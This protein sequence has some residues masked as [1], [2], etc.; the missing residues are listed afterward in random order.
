MAHEFGAQP[1]QVGDLD[2]TAWRALDRD[3][4]VDDVEVLRRRLELLGRDLEQLAPGLLGRLV[5]GAADAVGDLAATRRGT[6]GRADR[7]PD[8]D[9]DA[10]RRDAERLG[11]DH[12]QAGGRPADVRR[13]DRD[14]HRSVHLDAASRG[15]RRAGAAPGAKRHPHRL[16]LGQRRRVDG[17][18]AGL[19]EDL[20]RRNARPRLAVRR[21]VALA[22]HV[23]KAQLDG[24]HAELCGQLVHCG[25]QGEVRLRRAGGAVRVDRGLVRRDLQSAQVEVRDPVGAAEEARR[26]ARV[27]SRAGSVVVVKPCAQGEQRA[28]PARSELDVELRRRRGMADHEVLRAG[29]GQANGPVQANG[30]EGEQRLEELDLAAEPAADRHGDDAHLVRW[31]AD[32]RGDRVPDDEGSLRGRPHGEAAVGLGADDGDVG[33]QEGVV[34]PC[35]AVGRLDHDVRVL[36]RSLGVAALEMRDAAHVARPFL[37]RIVGGGRG[38]VN[39]GVL[40]ARA[41]FLLEDERRLLSHCRGGV[42]DRSG[43][44]VVDLDEGRRVRS[45]GLAFSHHRRDGLPDVKDASHRQRQVG[46]CALPRRQVGARDHVD[47]SRH[48]AGGAGVDGADLSARN[49]GQDQLHVQQA[50]QLEVGGETGRPGDLFASFLAPHAPGGYAHHPKML[51]RRLCTA[52][53]TVLLAACSNGPNGGTQPTSLATDQTLRC[54]MQ[55]DVSTLDPAMFDTEAEAAIAHN[56]FDGLLRFDSNLTIPPDIASA[57]P[58]V[59]TDGATYTFKLRQDVIFSNGDKVT[60]KDVLYSWNRAA[61]MQGPYAVNLS[62]IMGY[63]HVATNQSAGAALESLLEKNDPAVTMAGLSAPDP[64]TV[65]VKLTG[66]AGW[67]D[68][69]IAQPAVAG[70]I[71]DQNIVKGNFENWW[72]KPETLVGTGA[73]KMSAHTADQSLDFSSLP[74]WWGRPKPTLSKIHVEVVADPT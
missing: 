44:F 9:T 73:Y 51:R 31:Q 38:A 54:P 28:I 3:L 71:V 14:R 40:L 26:Q 46:A 4:A 52:L 13:S 58:T 68:S 62:A 66:A 16:A 64:Y 67:F 29:E 35:H 34:R 59:S 2:R 1:D 36:Q 20:D 37:G 60:S 32:E 15:R 55:H 12:G 18:A 33:L 63:D 72:S 45:R 39:R 10:I 69:A 30:E 7:V 49:V 23:A 53:L 65:V 11:G 5:H 57:L 56:V 6:E 41:L 19:L 50:G 25:L 8:L 47:D 22:G 17:M 61:A 43:L 21:E 42:D 70:M 27:P 74:D 48:R 24:I